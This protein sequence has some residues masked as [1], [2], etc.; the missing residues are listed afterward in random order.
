MNLGDYLIDQEG[1][2]W[3]ALLRDWSFPEA[4]TIWM[5]NRFGDLIVIYDDGSVHWLDVAD[6]GMERIAGDAESFKAQFA[7]NPEQ[8]LL[9]PLVDRCIAAGLTLSPQQCYGYKT[10]PILGGKC[11]VENIVPIS[12]AEHYSF[13]AYLHK[14][15]EDLPDGAQ[16]RL[17][18]GQEPSP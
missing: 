13:H 1:K 16:V 8:W 6:G 3:Q 11:E 4:F 12:L 5:V 14:Q 18:V 15:T 17:V 9:S 10:P 7:T 2:D